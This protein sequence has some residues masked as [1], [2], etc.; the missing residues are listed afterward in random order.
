MH[1]RLLS[2]RGCL[3]EGAA[4]ARRSESVVERKTLEVQT[5]LQGSV[6]SSQVSTGPYYLLA[7]HPRWTVMTPSSYDVCTAD[8]STPSPL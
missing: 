1:R 5:V 2:R 6:T 4:V 7:S 3:L 8:L